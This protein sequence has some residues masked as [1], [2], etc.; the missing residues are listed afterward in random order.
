MKRY[1]LFLM[2][3]VLLVSGCK[4][5]V[6]SP[7]PTAT[8]TLEPPTPINSPTPTP[9]PM[10]ALVNGTPILLVDYERQVASYEASLLAQG[11]DTS[12]SEGQQQLVEA[13]SWIL[14]QMIEQVLIEQAAAQAGV[15]VSDDEVTAAVQALEAELGADVLAQRLAQE[16]LT[17]ESLRIELKRQM[18]ISKMA[19][20]VVNA[21]PARAEHVRA[22][23]ILVATQADAEQVLA[24]LQAGADFAQLAMQVSLDVN[25]RLN[26]G[27]LGYFPRGVLS[28]PEVEQAAF[29]LDIGALSAV[30]QSALGYHIIQ[31]LD[32]GEREVSPEHQV[33]LQDKAL[34]DW[35]A[36]LWAQ[37]D[38]QRLVTPTP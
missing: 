22:R 19:T 27:D 2:G 4:P 11:V 16:G 12:T 6:S 7:A 33:L 28:V 14:D 24:Q 17:Q 32:K 8:A 29:A 3:L 21:V 10:A 31:V 9:E 23:H 37:A 36:G 34:R 1:G 38:I 25:T 18:L 35:L 20:Q 15:S 13:R 26:G 5:T 30:V